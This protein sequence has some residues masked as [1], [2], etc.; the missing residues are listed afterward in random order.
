[1]DSVHRSPATSGHVPSDTHCDVAKFHSSIVTGWPPAAGVMLAPTVFAWANGAPGAGRPL[2]GLKLDAVSTLPSTA[3]RLPAPP[4]T[5]P[6]PTDVGCAERF[7][8][9]I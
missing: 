6:P 9:R 8:S 7:Q 4:E 1:M 2:S 3:C 5:T